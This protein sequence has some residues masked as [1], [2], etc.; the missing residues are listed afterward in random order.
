MPPG[1]TPVDSLARGRLPPQ[2]H[3]PRQGTSEARAAGERWATQAREIAERLAASAMAAG[4]RMVVAP[5][6]RFVQPGR[7]QAARHRA[8]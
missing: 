1:W 3:E 2:Q 5:E 8:T 4:P 6:A 7:T